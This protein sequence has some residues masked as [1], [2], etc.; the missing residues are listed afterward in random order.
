MFYRLP[1]YIYVYLKRHTHK[2]DNNFQDTDNCHS[3]LIDNKHVNNVVIQIKDKENKL[4]PDVEVQRKKDVFLI[5]LV[6][7]RA[8]LISKVQGIKH[9]S[10][11]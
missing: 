6:I 3:S 10:E 5:H 8:G 1:I 11:V 7:D 2:K 9:G 4:T